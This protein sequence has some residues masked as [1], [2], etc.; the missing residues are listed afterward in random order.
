MRALVSRKLSAL[1]YSIG[2]NLKIRGVDA[3]CLTNQRGDCLLLVSN[4][5]YGP[6]W[7]QI[8]KSLEHLVPSPALITHGKT[9]AV[10]VADSS[11]ARELVGGL[12][13]NANASRG[14]QV[15][16][17]GIG[18]VELESKPK[19]D[20]KPLAL[21]L[22]SI[23]C[24]VALG[25]FWG[26]SQQKKQSVVAAA[27]VDTC[28]VD[29]NPADFENWLSETLNSEVTLGAGIELQRQ[30]ELGQLNIVV[31][32]TIGSAAKV[33]GVAVCADGRERLVN[34]RIDT[35]GEGAVFELGS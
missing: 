4:V 9:P 2:K 28:V 30:T 23:V 17:E 24:V 5:F 18:F 1:G 10:L 11:I 32:N 16:L 34:H 29:L 20:L 22:A 21:P 25:I 8:F 3:T 33:T 26:G 27:V 14:K 15:H 7:V 6:S 12:F 35:S 19:P 31:E 13:E